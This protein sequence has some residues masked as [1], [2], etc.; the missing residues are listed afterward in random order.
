MG[1][2]RLRRPGAGP[3]R[4]SSWPSAIGK[5]LAQ[6]SLPSLSRFCIITLCHHIINGSLPFHDGNLNI[7][8]RTATRVE[9]EAKKI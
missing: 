9:S 2:R 7:L 1:P 8:I 6:A 4:P 5:I 3:R